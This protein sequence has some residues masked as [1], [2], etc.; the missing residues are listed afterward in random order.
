MEGKNPLT[1]YLKIQP[2]FKAPIFE[3][4][5]RL[6]KAFKKG[7]NNKKRPDKRVGTHNHALKRVGRTTMALTNDRNPPKTGLKKGQ[8]T[9]KR[10]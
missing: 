5:K 10:P 8:G 2:A 4:L 6:K 3:A 7:R 1:H 9:L